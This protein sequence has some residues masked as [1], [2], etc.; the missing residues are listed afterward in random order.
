MH[1]CKSND[2][3]YRLQVTLVNK[4]EYFMFEKTI[5]TDMAKERRGG[6]RKELY[7]GRR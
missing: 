2:L 7:I 3:A 6:Y 4:K 1:S 5:F